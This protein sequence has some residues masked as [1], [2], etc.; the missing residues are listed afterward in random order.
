MENESCSLGFNH[1]KSMEIL[2]K[3]LV[4][5]PPISPIVDYMILDLGNK[6]CGH[7]L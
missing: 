6:D 2:G 1:I 3:S 7:L 4:K 5:S